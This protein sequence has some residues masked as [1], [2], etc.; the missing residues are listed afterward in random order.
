MQ[1]RTNAS[2]PASW[3]SPSSDM[4]SVVT[5]KDKEPHTSTT[6]SLGPALSHLHAPHSDT[7]CGSIGFV[8]VCIKSGWGICVLR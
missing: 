5:T 7:I 3:T 2:M 6:V 1:A 8:G 4:R